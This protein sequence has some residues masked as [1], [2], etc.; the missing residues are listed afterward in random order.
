[1]HTTIRLLIILILIVISNS[2]LPHGYIG[3][4]FFPSAISQD[5]PFINDKIALPIFYTEGPGQNNQNIWTTNPK[6]EYAKTI[7]HYFQA[8]VTGSYLHINNPDGNTENGFDNWEIGV[9]YNL[10]LLPQTESIFSVAL[11]SKIGGSG[12]HQVD[13]P[14]TT[15]SP[16]VLFAQGLGPLPD[17][18]KFL[19]PIGFSISAS[20]N[21]T[22]STSTVSSVSLGAAIE[23]DLPYLQQVVAHYNIPILDHLVPIVEFPFTVCT[24]GTCSGLTT[25]TIDPGIIVYGKYGQVATE[26]IIPANSKT[27]SKVGGVIQFYLYLDHVFPNSIGK[28]IFASS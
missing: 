20:P 12:S 13:S 25:G 23:Y 21:I 9:R 24:Q 26:A 11:N 10:F 28:P 6:L 27:G 17:A 1:M 14:Q 4:R 8:S 18:L 16:E 19:K 2:A 3:K 7:T 15:I 5:E 22:T